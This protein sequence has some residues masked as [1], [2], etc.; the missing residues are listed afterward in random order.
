MYELNKVWFFIKICFNLD[1]MQKIYSNL[2]EKNYNFNEYQ[3]F[4]EN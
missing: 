3:I 4:N 2:K 1:L